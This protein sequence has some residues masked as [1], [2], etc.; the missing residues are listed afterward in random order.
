MSYVKTTWT[1]HETKVTAA[2]MNHIEDGIEANDSAI[3]ANIITDNVSNQP[4]ASVH[5][6]ANDMRSAFGNGA[7]LQWGM[8]AAGRRALRRDF[9]GRQPAVRCGF[10]FTLSPADVDTKVTFRCSLVTA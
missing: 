7:Y 6:G 5:D 3:A 8:A 10:H 9:R 1:A 4:V 2:A